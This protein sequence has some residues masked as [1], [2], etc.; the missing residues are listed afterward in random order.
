MAK[1]F[2]V[3]DGEDVT[4][5]PGLQQIICG[6]IPS[7]EDLKDCVWCCMVFVDGE[8]DLWLVY[9]Q[10]LY[11]LSKYYEGKKITSILLRPETLLTKDN[12]IITLDS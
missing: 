1:I 2:K 4:E 9:R 5:Y 11:Y 8:V 10:G 6:S 7:I 12:D 3:I